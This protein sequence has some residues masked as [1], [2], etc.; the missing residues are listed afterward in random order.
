M[1]SKNIP[2]L[3]TPPLYRIWFTWIDPML[4]L[5]G[6]FGGLFQPHLLL[7]HI[8]ATISN[9]NVDPA[10]APNDPSRLMPNPDTNINPAQALVFNQFGA[11]CI[12]TFLLSIFLLRSTN[13]LSIW[14]TYQGSKCV[15]DIIV[16]TLIVLEYLRQ[17]RLSPSLWTFDDWFS[18]PITAWCAVLRASFVLGVGFDKKRK[19]I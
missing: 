14:K 7:S 12:F 19:S 16:V 4:S 8:P 15:A 13:D 1:A 6:A 10:A 5:L 3:R 2:Q 18:L 11:F 9:P 17:G